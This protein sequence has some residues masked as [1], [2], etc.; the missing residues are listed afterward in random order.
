MNQSIQL[1]GC[2]RSIM[3]TNWL[4]VLIKYNFTQITGEHI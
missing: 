1:E 2:R 4:T 3:L